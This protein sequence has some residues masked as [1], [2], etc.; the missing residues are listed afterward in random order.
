MACPR[1]RTMRFWKPCDHAPGAAPLHPWHATPTTA[2]PPGP[3]PQMT[4]RVSHP[5]PV[6]ASC[7]AGNMGEGTRYQIDFLFQ[8]CHN[9][10]ASRTLEKKS[11]VVS[12]GEGGFLSGSG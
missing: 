11:L 6:F 12:F 8:Y 5:G 7:G 2:S 10:S 3:A 1:L 9:Y 4:A